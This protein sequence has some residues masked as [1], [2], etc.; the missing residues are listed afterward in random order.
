MQKLKKGGVVGDISTMRNISAN[1]SQNR[2]RG[3]G[4]NF[5]PYTCMPERGKAQV[6]LISISK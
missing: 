6:S 4:L 5:N 1:V 2:K 3:L